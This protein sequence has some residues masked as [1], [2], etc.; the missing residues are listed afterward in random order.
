M[1]EEELENTTPRGRQS[2]NTKPNDAA[3]REARRNSA[4]ALEKSARAGGEGST[5][6]RT[7]AE[8]VG[9]YTMAHVDGNI[10]GNQG[11]ADI[12]GNTNNDVERNHKDEDRQ[13]IKEARPIGLWKEGMDSIRQDEHH[14][15]YNVPEGA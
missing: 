2:Y 12:A 10:R 3:D 11:S 5:G 13:R 4:S 9:E 1:T 6:R 7:S 14:M 8:N 15:G